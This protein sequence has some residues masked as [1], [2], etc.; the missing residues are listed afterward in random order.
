MLQTYLSLGRSLSL[1]RCQVR[2]N[3]EVVV[4]NIPHSWRSYDLRGAF[5]ECAAVANSHVIYTRH[6]GSCGFGYV[7]IE[8]ERDVDPAV[9]IM[10]GSLLVYIDG[11]LCIDAGV[12]WEKDLSSESN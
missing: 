11:R 12:E 9:A 1:V 5:E 8:Y 6:G 3:F 7:E 10:V 4:D 2:E